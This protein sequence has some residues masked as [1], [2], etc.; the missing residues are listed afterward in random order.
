MARAQYLEETCKSAL[1]RVPERAGCRSAGPSTPIEAARTAAITASRARFT[2]TRP[3]RRGGL[4]HEDRGQDE[5]R[6]GAAARARLAALDGRAHCDGDGDRPVPALRGPLPADARRDRS[7]W[8][9]REP[10]VD[11][12]EV[13]DDPARPRSL[14]APERGRAAHDLDELP[15]STRR[16]AA[17][18]SRGPRRV[19]SARDPLALRGGRDPNGRARRADP[20]G[21]DRRPASGRGG[22]RVRGRRRRLRSPIV[23]HVRTSIR[24]HFMPWMQEHYPWLYPRYVELYGGRSYAPKSF[25]QEVAERFARL[26]DKHGVGAS[27]HRR[28]RAGAEPARTADSGCL[29]SLR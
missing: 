2:R 27:G 22:G 28:G 8:R 15:D 21:S 6:R 12:D 4:L 1:N 24:E 29:E 20:P 9:V 5:R 25:Q 10:A 17:S 18:S 13:D 26:R 19:A 11:A 23:L 3:G 16:F 14:Q 7:D